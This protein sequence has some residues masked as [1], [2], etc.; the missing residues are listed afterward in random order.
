LPIFD[1]FDF[2]NLLSVNDQKKNEGVIYPNPAK[3][4]I[5]F[6]DLGENTQVVV[7]DVFGRIILNKKTTENKLDVSELKP[8]IYYFEFYVN[9][10]KVVKKIVID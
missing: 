6:K 2:C 7:Y 1:V 4:F 3:G 5:Y 10:S 9:E 8:G